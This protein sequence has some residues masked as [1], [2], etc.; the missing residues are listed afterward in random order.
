MHKPIT[1]LI[2]LIWLTIY[3]SFSW[4]KKRWK[5]VAA[6]TTMIGGALFT[7]YTTDVMQLS[8]L[9][10][11][12][13]EVADTAVYIS[14]DCKSPRHTTPLNDNYIELQSE[15]SELLVKEQFLGKILP[16]SLYCSL[17]RFNIKTSAI[18]SV[19][20]ADVCKLKLENPNQL[21]A[22]TNTRVSV[23]K[24]DA[25]GYKVGINI[26][27]LKQFRNYDPDSCLNN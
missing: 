4:I 26:F 5:T 1:T 7:L 8:D 24:K 20:E 16:R 23:I 27:E 10:G 18:V 15:F 22:E 19:P 11:Y 25:L 21:T 17:H 6:I 13:K 14:V 12:Q 9:A 2:K 3:K